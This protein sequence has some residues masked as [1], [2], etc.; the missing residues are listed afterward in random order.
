MGDQSVGKTAV[1]VRL[2][3]LSSC[4]DLTTGDRT[5][6]LTEMCAKAVFEKH[7]RGEGNGKSLGLWE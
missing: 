5:V 3:Q 7:I 6:E 4:W 1:V 2:P